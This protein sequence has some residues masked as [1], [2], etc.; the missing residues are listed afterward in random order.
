LG[1]A[2]ANDVH[3][4]NHHVAGSFGHHVA[5]LKLRRSD[6]TVKVCKAGEAWFSATVGGLGLTGI[7]M[8]ATVKLVPVLSGLMQRRV[9]KL[10]GLE[11]FFAVMDGVGRE[12][13]YSVAWLD[14]TAPEKELGRGYLELARWDDLGG[15]LEPPPPVR[16]NVPLRLP[17]SAVNAL[18]TRVFNELWLRRPRAAYAQ[19]GYSSFFWPLDGVG[20]WTRLYG[21][22]PFVQCQAVVPSAGAEQLV[23]EILRLARA[24]GE[25]S[26]LNTLKTMGGMTP[27][28]MLSFPREGVALALDFPYK[29]ERTTAMLRAIEDVVMAN[30]GAL[31][32]AKDAWMRAESFRQAY[33]AWKAFLKYKDENMGS[34][35]WQRVMGEK[36]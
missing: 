26:F 3:G 2:I 28:G 11:D 36:A 4:K 19:I 6:G 14:M 22:T 1:G 9:V 5:A 12:W 15:P 30:G 24:G 21:P 27:A 25:P 23:A 33:P 35:F 20:H 13:D 34:D 8:E 32:P 31:Y 17:V 18:T 29:G 16:L 7:I 10:R